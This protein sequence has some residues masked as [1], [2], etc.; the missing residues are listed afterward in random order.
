MSSVDFDPK[1]LDIGRDILNNTDKIVRTTIT[2]FLA[3]F[4]SVTKTAKKYKVNLEG[5]VSLNGVQSSFEEFGSLLSGMDR[6]ADI[7]YGLVDNYQK[8]RYGT[9]EGTSFLLSMCMKQANL[10]NP[11]PFTRSVNTFHLG[12]LL[13]TSSF[14]GYFADIVGCATTI[15]GGAY[16]L[17]GDALDFLKIGGPLRGYFQTR[18]NVDKAIATFTSTNYLKKTDLYKQIRSGSYFGEDSLYGDVWTTAGEVSAAYVG[19]EALSLSSASKASSTAKE[20]APYGSVKVPGFNDLLLGVASNKVRKD[21]VDIVHNYSHNF[22]NHYKAGDDLFKSVVSA[23][24][25]TGDDFI[26]DMA[27]DAVTSK[28]G[29][30]IRSSGAGEVIQ[31]LDT[32]VIEKVG[33]KTRDNVVGAAKAIGS[34]ASSLF[35]DNVDVNSGQKKN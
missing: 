7:D 10:V 1:Q 6:L 9:Y 32:E 19:S 25:E 4:D 26:K 8:G 24:K 23:G 29:K 34:V 16:G 2:D 5:T 15:R 31:K 33:K 14:V 21:A 17:V 35:K 12:Q 28:L 27:T 22:N 30:K 11:D 18:E 13:S 3:D 20:A